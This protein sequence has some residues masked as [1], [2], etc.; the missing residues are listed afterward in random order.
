MI[1]YAS[2]FDL[3]GNLIS[4]S[5]AFS[6]PRL[7]FRK[8]LVFIMLKPSLQGFK[9]DLT[10]KGNDCNCLMVTLLGNY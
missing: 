10:S 6:K 3:F 4:V 5:S 8:F 1:E 7:N 2:E 9:H